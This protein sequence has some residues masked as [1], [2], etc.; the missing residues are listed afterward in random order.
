M[1][2]RSRMITAVAL[3]GCA[4]LGVGGSAHA[5]QDAL[6]QRLTNILPK[7]GTTVGLRMAREL[8]LPNYLGKDLSPLTLQP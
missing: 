1:R 6:R 5:Q 2:R 3:M 4:W 7:V 8:Q